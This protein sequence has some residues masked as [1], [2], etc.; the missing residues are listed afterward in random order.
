MKSIFFIIA[1]LI[2]YGSLYPF[3]FSANSMSPESLQALLN[4]D[5]RQTSLTDIIANI[6]LFIPFGLFIR[7]VFPNQTTKIQMLNLALLTFVFAY[8]IQALQLF[9]EDRKP[10]G[11]DAVWN[12]VGYFVGL[13]LYSFSQLRF[14]RSIQTLSINGQICLVLAISIIVLELAPFAPSIDL[15]VLKQNVKALLS[16]P[17][18]DWYWTVE[19]TLYWLVPFYLLKLAVP[20]FASLPRLSFI[21]FGVLL[22]KFIIVSSNVNLTLLVSGI[23]ALIVWG[24]FGRRINIGFLAVLMLIKIVSNGLHPFVLSEQTQ[25]FNWIPFTGSMNGNILF[26]IVVFAKK[27]AIYG[28]TIWLL[29]LWS[30]RLLMSTLVCVAALLMTELL[31][32]RFVDSTPESTDLVLAV[33]IAF[34][35]KQVIKPS[36]SHNKDKPLASTAVINGEQLMKSSNADSSSNKGHINSKTKRSLIAISSF[37][38]VIVFGTFIYWSSADSG[39]I[40]V[41]QASWIKMNNPRL[42]FDHHTHSTYSDGSLNIVELAEL[43]Y[44][45][46]CDAFA[47]TDHSDNIDNFR[48]SRF[49]DIRAVREKYPVMM[50]FGGIEVEMPSYSGREHVNILTLPE[51]EY[52]VIQGLFK[53]LLSIDERPKSEWDSSVLDSIY[54]VPGAGLNSVAIYNHPSRKDLD[55]D[56]DEN[57]VD[58]QDWNRNFQHIIGVS[59]APGHQN[60]EA[61]GSYETKIMP[62][63]R[64]DP[65]AA[66][67]GG[68]WDRLLSEGEQIW[69]AVASSDYHS[70]SMDYAPCEF[71]RIHVNAPTRDYEG[72]IRA[73][74]AGTFWADHGKLLQDYR[75]TVTSQDG[76]QVAHPGATIDLAG[77][78]NVLAVELSVTKSPEYSSD[79][80]RFELISNCNREET[81]L[82]SKLLPPEQ[83][84]MSVVFPIFDK[85]R[86]EQCYVRSRV[87]RE[88]V[89]KNRLS[90][91]SNPIFIKY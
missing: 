70:D 55:K 14:L 76:K 79:Y 38:L 64:W 12:M 10:W 40:K 9:T 42:I 20:S 74:K 32:T 27:I 21:V 88:S 61:I 22:A 66:T 7:L 28:A 35:L 51:Y 73:L 43:A 89:E 67:V 6:V 81:T 30:Q 3:H 18:I 68:T 87:I 84:T 2:V 71:S 54:E 82:E 39:E 33:F 57:Y 15:D 46:G 52:P 16:N 26:N 4:F 48:Q 41:R 31:Q 59:G 69:A 90:A 29:F 83:D 25:A 17:T 50:V 63:D 36:L 23:N 72:I 49:D 8:G 24:V 56:Q 44:I 75:L 65:F 78:N 91:Y 45:K 86:G 19:G 34:I 5:V 11:G 77:N 37:L 60:K 53:S 58:I 62:I 85:K 47:V 13:V 1:F 80:L